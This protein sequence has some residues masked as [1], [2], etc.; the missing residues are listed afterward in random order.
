MH[1]SRF[2]I[3][4][5]LLVLAAGAQAQN[6]DITVS[7]TE[8]SFDGVCDSDC[9]LREAITLASQRQ[10]SQ[11][12]HLAAGVY[13]LSLA[14]PQD[15]AGNP[16]EEHENLNGDLDVRYVAVTLLGA[17]MTRTVIDAG[18]LDRHFD[19]VAGAGLHLQDLT[20]RN[21]FHSSEGGVLRN[22][23]VVELKRVRLINNQVRF[24]QRFG[25]GGAIANHQ[26]LRVLQSEFIRNHLVGEFGMNYDPEAQGGAI[27]NARDLL[28]R[29]S[30]F[31]GSRA[32][33][34]YQSGGGA[35]YNTGFADVARSAF[36]GNGSTGN[37]GAV[38]NADNGV[39]GMSNST[40]SSNVTLYGGALAN[41]VEYSE[42]PAS[43]KAHLV[44]LTIAANEGRGLYN[45]GY[46]RVRNSVVVRNS[47]TN[48]TSSGIFSEFDGRGLMLSDSNF[49]GCT[50]DFIV[51]NARV[52]NE[53]LYPI[54]TNASGTPGHPLR[55]G[56][57]AVDAGISAC[58]SHDQ[59]AV[60]RPR[61]G[62]GDGVARCDL[63]AFEL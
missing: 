62:D 9:S 45:A 19:V 10:G 6:A 20:L 34:N 61:D 63:G 58:A 25:R 37:G 5:G 33:A 55:F 12:I 36:I 24:A 53:V 1:S 38:A 28:V 15:A 27:Y 41:G 57:P 60:A 8:D 7:K 49:H 40:L 3:G 26:S 59:R 43:P 32:A 42:T 48:C 2:L 44:H 50:A 51:D 22:Y 21:G 14:P 35:L 56:S 11:R 29:D 30:V 52:F 47:G 4:C 17:G 54:D 31:R 39:L 18:Q 13:Q 16:L 46:A 23:G